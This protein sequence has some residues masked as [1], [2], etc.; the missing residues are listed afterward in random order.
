MLPGAALCLLA[1]LLVLPGLGRPAITDSDEAYYAEAAREMIE[2]GDY[3]TPRFNYA[4][5][6]QKPVLYYWMAAASYGVA[7]VNAAAARFPSALAGVG[8]VGLAF[9]TGR[10]WWGREEA[11]LAAAIVAT[12]LGCFMAAH[13]A[14]PDLPLAFLVTAATWAGLVALESAGSGP[15]R[16][17][18]PLLGC[19]AAAGLAFLTKGPVGVVVPAV[20]LVPAAIVDHAWRRLRVADLLLA[21]AAFLVVALPWYLAMTAVHGRAYL[22][23]FFVGDNLERF[24][25][26]R[27]N[28]PRG[29]WFYLPVLL[30][31][32]LPWS[33]LFLVG[34]APLWRALSRPAVVTTQAWR[35]A[36]WA[37]APLALFTMSIGKQPRYILPV[38][39]P[40]AVALAVWTCEALRRDATSSRTPGAPR[41]AAALCGALV[42]AV[43][44]FPLLGHPVFSRGPGAVR[45]LCGATAVSSG[46]LVIAVGWRRVQLFPPTMALAAAALLVTLQATVF[47]QPQPE[48]VEEVAVA[49][50]SRLQPGEAWTTREA[51]SRNL[52]FYVGSR[53]DGPFDVQALASFLGAADRRV[54]CAMAA[55]ELDRLR[56]AHPGLVLHQ[57]GE[58][59]FFNLAGARAR[60]ILRP[61]PR[62]DEKVVVLV[63]NRPD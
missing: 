50:R 61:D 7:G 16:A 13:L 40:V 55:R 28:E 33:P 51:L 60:S 47:W 53:Q 15:G 22:E 5:R 46:L 23:S 45:V 63:S 39:V 10:R 26:A 3:L 48:A 38:M 4:N 21:T 34:V 2:S 27:F 19:A 9:V 18:W 62:R 1:A 14:L 57:L 11:T 43:G 49:L 30:G 12:S 24:A 58:W 59:R 8:L 37:L 20:I 35:L 52:V 17:R 56:A 44:L 6:F 25:T 29:P 31:G 54:Y 36:A 41:V 42:V 32:M